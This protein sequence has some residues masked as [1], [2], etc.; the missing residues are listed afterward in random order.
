MEN[1]QFQVKVMRII[2]TKEIFYLP[3]FFS[4]YK[5]KVILC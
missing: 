1:T 2:K 4:Q 5:K 3:Y